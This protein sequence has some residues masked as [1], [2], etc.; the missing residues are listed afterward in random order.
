MTKFL[1]GLINL[2]DSTI[3][4]DEYMLGNDARTSQAVLMHKQTLLSNA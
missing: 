3:L 1:A 4:Y 2:C